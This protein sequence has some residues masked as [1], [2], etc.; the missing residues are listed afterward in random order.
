MKQYIVKKVNHAFSW[1]DIETAKVDVFNWQNF[2]GYDP[3]AEFKMVHDD[4]YLYIK[5]TAN[6]DYIKNQCT[7]INDFVCGDSCME[8][9]L[10]TP[11]DEEHYI[12]FE[13]NANGVAF[14]G[15]GDE[16]TKRLTLDPDII[17]KNLIV[18]AE[19]S[20]VAENE[21]GKWSLTVMIK[22]EFFPLI[23]GKEFTSGCTGKGNVYKC[24]DRVISHFISWNEIHTDHPNF[25]VPQAFGDLIFE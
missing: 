23:T 21:R 10:S 5:L 4:N 16:K 20:K 6:N 22:K 12:N 3:E 13:F 7:E 19:P 25:H 17:R 8:A 15:Y 14:V 1:T 9:F 18:M 24:G 2:K 11:G